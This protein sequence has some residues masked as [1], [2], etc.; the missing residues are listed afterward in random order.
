MKLRLRLR[1]LLSRRREIVVLRLW[2]ERSDRGGRLRIVV[3]T[4]LWSRIVVTLR[5]SRREIGSHWASAV[6]REVWQIQ[7]GD[8]KAHRSAKLVSIEEKKVSA[9]RQSPDVPKGGE[10]LEDRKAGGSV[11]LDHIKFFFLGDSEIELKRK[12]SWCTHDQQYMRG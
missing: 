10:R 11:S 6:K 9:V 5:L 7:A 2:V 3:L 1:L 8:A 12:C 4:L